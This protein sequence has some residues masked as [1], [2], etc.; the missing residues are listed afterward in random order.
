MRDDPGIG[1]RAARRA[2]SSIY[3]TV[4]DVVLTGIVVILPLVV[5]LYVLSAALRLV[6]SAL[7]PLIQLLQWAGLIQGL[8]QRVGVAFLI[9]IGLY[10][11]VAEFL[12]EFLALTV[13]VV[14]I[15]VVGAVGRFHYGERLIDYFDYFITSLPGIG[16]IYKSFRRMG[17]VFLENGADEFRDVKLVEFPHHDVYT[18]GFETSTT[19]PTIQAAADIEGMVTL[20]LPL[21]PN[22]VM[23]GFLA[24]VREERVNEVDMTVEE[25]VRMTIT[26][27]VATETG[28]EY[29]RL[30]PDERRQIRTLGYDEE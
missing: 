15:V 22:P 18:I 29:R 6:G 13:L 25:A 2:G 10:A 8:K 7:R 23:G 5:T 4:I 19:P 26:S 14:I 12:T 20:F 3:R 17:D 30:D 28:E 24:H 11:N 16:A 27:G 21:A 1:R 9:E